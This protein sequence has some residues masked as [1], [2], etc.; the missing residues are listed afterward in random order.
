LLSHFKEK[1]A[2]KG[3]FAD[4]DNEEEA[5]SIR[6]EVMVERLAVKALPNIAYKT[7]K[8]LHKG[9]VV[10]AVEARGG[11]V[12]LKG[13]TAGVS[14]GWAPVSL[15]DSD[16]SAGGVVVGAIGRTKFNFNDRKFDDNQMNKLTTAR[17]VKR[18]S[19]SLFSAAFSSPL[20]AEAASGD[21][22]DKIDKNENT[23]LESGSVLCLRMLVPGEMPEG[24]AAKKSALEK[25]AL[26]DRQ[27][28]KKKK[29]KKQHPQE[30]RMPKR[31]AVVRVRDETAALNCSRQVEIGGQDSC[32]DDGANVEV[33]YPTCPHSLPAV[34][35]IHRDVKTS[36]L[37]P[38]PPP[39]LSFSTERSASPFDDFI[40]SDL[41][42]LD[43]PLAPQPCPAGLSLLDM[44]IFQ[45][46]SIRF[47]F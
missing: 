32:Q 46:T 15:A 8:V 28:K 13:E 41:P 34:F 16:E 43:L 20:A 27:T 30:W 29:T 45:N 33:T 23:T 18:I 47:A 22:V 12:N 6:Y 42:P 7:E 25:G 38:P 36:P 2:A 3:N 26:Q 9:S 11:W 40:L 21:E 35:A 14:G 24:Q 17:V 44:D 19:L 4:I 10:V 1:F 37:L 31:V 5:D 39:L